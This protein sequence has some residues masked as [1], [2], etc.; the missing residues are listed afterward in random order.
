MD[1][2]GKLAMVALVI[3]NTILVLSMR[4]SRMRRGSSTDELYT[5]STAVTVME[6]LKLLTCLGVLYAQS[7]S[8]AK[9]SN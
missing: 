2:R 9:V 7:P 1:V 5:I 8:Y 6:F 3:Q 4:Y